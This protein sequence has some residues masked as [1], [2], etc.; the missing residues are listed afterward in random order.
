MRLFF[1]SSINKEQKYG[2]NVYNAQ[3]HLVEQVVKFSKLLA[4][5]AFGTKRGHYVM[6]QI[7]VRT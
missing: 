6:H 3:L 5:K 4:K 7:A 2:S 1:G